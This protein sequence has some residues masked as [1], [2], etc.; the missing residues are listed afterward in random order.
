M[1][2]K[3]ET[4]AS[5]N[6]HASYFADYFKGRT[7]PELRSEFDIFINSLGGKTILD[8]GCGAGDH[9]L[10]FKQNGLDVT[11]VDLSEAMVRLCL[12]KG[13]RACV[14]DIEDL[15]FEDNSF[16]G[17][18]AV[19]SLLHISKENMLPVVRKLYSILATNGI[20][21]IC[22]KEGAGERFLVD[23]NDSSTRRF[24]SFWKKEELISL[25]DPYFCLFDFERRITG[26]TAFLYL[27]FRKR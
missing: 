13:L 1:D 26:D 9:G 19:T 16:G 5:Y 3:S 22:M 24:F 4:L 20:L 25:F 23:K 2:Y 11:C 17:I 14:M 12:D 18:W 21:H 8:L 7:S 15:Q 27:F 10:Y 6:K